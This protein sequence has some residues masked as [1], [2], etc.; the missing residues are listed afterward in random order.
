M[1]NFITL[2]FL[3]M[4]LLTSCSKEEV[5]T[6]QECPAQ[7]IRITTGVDIGLTTKAAITTG[8]FPT[9]RDM[10]VSSWHA[11]SS[12]NHFKS[13]RF[14][15]STG[16]WMAD[17]SWPL[18]GNL[19]FLAISQGSSSITDVTWGTPDA[20]ASV[21]FAMPDNSSVQEDI[22]IGCAASIAANTDVVIDFKHPQAL[23][24]FTAKSSDAYNSTTN[25]GITINSIT[26]KS[27]KYSGT[28]LAQ[29][30]SGSLEFFWSSLG[31]SKTVAVP[32]LTTTNLTKTVT[33]LGDG[34][35]LPEQTEVGFVISYTLHNGTDT[36]GNLVNTAMSYDYTPS[37][38]C[39]WE[40]GKKYTYGI[41]ITMKGINITPSVA[42]WDTGANKEIIL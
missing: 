6:G 37:S 32:G 7:L 17:K 35:L 3:G 1:K 30:S 11:A 4:M 40:A 41:D 8:V 22:L 19:D 15:Y 18:S 26:L 23:L 25:R 5:K 13:T 10:I 27:A 31:S 21:Q 28:V 38:P 42:L 24:V 20:T 36:A 14:T 29:R 39:S 33:T 12:Q 16:A 9:T 2:I 34:I